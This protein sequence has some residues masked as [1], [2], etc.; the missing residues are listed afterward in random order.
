M[1]TARILRLT[2]NPQPQLDNLSP[3]DVVALEL[4]ID[5]KVLAIARAIFKGDENIVENWLNMPNGALDDIAPIYLLNTMAGIDR[6]GRVLIDIAY[7]FSN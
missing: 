1:T 2:P 3:E 5:N 7:G 4:A 6:V